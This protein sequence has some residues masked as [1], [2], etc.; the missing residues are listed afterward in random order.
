M[1]VAPS[2][3]RRDPSSLVSRKAYVPS[4]GT[5]RLAMTWET[6]W[7][8]IPKSSVELQSMV[9]INLST[10]GVCPV[11]RSHNSSRGD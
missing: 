8:S 5:S 10:F 4:S 3:R 6:K 9:G 2:I 7:S 1:T 11:F